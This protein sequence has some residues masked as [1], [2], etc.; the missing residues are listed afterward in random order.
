ML[1]L[2]VILQIFFKFLIWFCYI[3]L[4]FQ[5]DHI[6]HPCSTRCFDLL[7]V[8]QRNPSEQMKPLGGAWELLSP[9]ISWWWMAAGSGNDVKCI[10]LCFL[11]TILG[12]RLKE[13]VWRSVET[14]SV[15]HRFR[16]CFGTEISL[17]RKHRHS[18]ANYRPWHIN[19]I[20]SSNYISQHCFLVYCNSLRGSRWNWPEPFKNQSP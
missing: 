3:L 15:L 17:A 16:Q 14:Q 7:Q 10:P 20:I 1:N 2:R 6:I 5:H 11:G 12:G 9:R 13:I 18:W 19:E 4:I 8:K